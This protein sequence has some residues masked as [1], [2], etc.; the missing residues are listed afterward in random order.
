MSRLPDW[1]ER[2]HAYLVSVFD[3]AFEWGQHDCGLFVCAAAEAVTGI[4]RAADLRGQYSTREGAS[5]ALKEI[6][7]GT[8]LRTMNA[9][10]TPK[11]VGMAHR[12]DI[13][14]FQ[15]SVGVCTGSTALFV[16]EERFAETAGIPHRTGLVSVHRSLWQ[17]AWA[18][19]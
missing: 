12:G 3:R 17:K 8:L 2:L 4:D 14:W 18:V 15:G 6:G 11:P 7:S 9:R 13:V 16:G 1:E 10:F 5:R 19:G